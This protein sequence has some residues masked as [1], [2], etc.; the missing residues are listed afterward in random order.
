MSI[1]VD[2]QLKQ[3]IRIPNLPL[4]KMVDE[5]GNATPSELTFRQTLISNLQTLFGNEA[6]AIPIQSPANIITIQNN[7]IINEATGIAQYSCQ[8]GTIL[9]S[10]HPTDYTQ[11]KIVVAVRNDNTYPLT[12]PIF[13]TFT[14]T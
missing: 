7:K 11:D 14:I 9:Y 2:L 10:Q 8:L 1:P 6:C 4:D 13:K 3:T 12:A 5:S